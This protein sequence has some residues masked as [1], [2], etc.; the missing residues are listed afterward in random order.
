MNLET[1]NFPRM[2]TSQTALTILLGLAAAG[3]TIHAE[4]AS[5]QPAQGQ[6]PQQKAPK[7]PVLMK[8][9]TA[10]QIVAAIGQPQ[11]KKTMKVPEGSTD[12]AETWVYRQEIG[13][14]EVQVATGTQQVAAYVG[15]GMGND[16][17]GSTPQIVFTNKTVTVYRVTSLLMVNGQLVLARQTSEQSDRYH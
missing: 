7:G 8:G 17:L 9:M 6:A 4:P 14:H 11:E 12:K 16:A 3:L 1:L 5:A 15:M 10:E 2:R 13:T